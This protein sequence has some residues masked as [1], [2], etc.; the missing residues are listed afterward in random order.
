MGIKV[1]FCEP[2]GKAVVRL[3]VYEDGACSREGGS[4]TYHDASSDRVE[5]FDHPTDE[6]LTIRS[7]VG[8][9]AGHAA[10]PTACACGH[11]FTDAADRQLRPCQLV[12]RTDT[13]ELFEGYRHLPP[14]AV[15][16]AFWMAEGRSWIG[17]DGRCLTCK[18][19]DGH[20]WIIDGQATNCTMPNDDVHKCWVR[21][22][23]PEDGN[24]H[25]DKNGNTCAA[26]AGSIATPKWHGFLHNGE[27]VVC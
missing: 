16:N 23:R 6:S 14:G 11:A 7:G 22:G 3:R 1:F 27:L 10:W 15:W 9:Y 8:E 17:A 2:V 26:G 21:H 25:V 12:Q 13:G 18:L 20:D 5:E 19:P 24:L 4:H